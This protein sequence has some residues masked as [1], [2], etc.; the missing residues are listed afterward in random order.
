MI[1][2]AASVPT[3]TGN[4]DT[5]WYTQFLQSATGAYQAYL[6]LEQQREL[7]KIQNQRAAAGLAPLDVSQYT[8][9]VS[10]GIAN[11]TQRTLLWIAGGLGAV[12]LASKLLK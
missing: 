2:D 1:G 12:Y 9:G 7:L 4:A 8:P 10:V 6:T 5:P 3:A 11:D